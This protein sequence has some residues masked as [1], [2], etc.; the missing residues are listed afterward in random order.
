MTIGWKIP[1]IKNVDMAMMIPV[2]YIICQILFQFLDAKVVNIFLKSLLL[3]IKIG[4]GQGV[5][6]EN[7]KIKN[8]TA[9]HETVVFYI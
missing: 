4:E 3:E 8:T 2:K 9:S 7:S 5:H 6:N 1:M